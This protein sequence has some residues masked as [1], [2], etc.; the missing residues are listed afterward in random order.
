MVGIAQKILRLSLIVRIMRTAQKKNSFG[1]LRDWWEFTRR[2][3]IGE[4]RDLLLV[5]CGRG[6]AQ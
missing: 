4:L 6:V 1:G 3:S 5:L 2:M